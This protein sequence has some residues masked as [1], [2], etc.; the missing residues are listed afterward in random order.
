MSSGV[1]NSLLRGRKGR[2]PAVA[3]RPLGRLGSVCL[4]SSNSRAKSAFPADFQPVVTIKRPESPASWPSWLIHCNSLLQLGNIRII[5][6]AALWGE[7]TT[8]GKLLDGSTRSAVLHGAEGHSR[9]FVAPAGGQRGG[10][11]HRTRPRGGLNHAGPGS[12]GALLPCHFKIS[13]RA[14]VPVQSAI[15]GASALRLIHRNQIDVTK[16]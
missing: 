3:G 11:S 4:E 9:R 13:R 14:L 15:T 1:G 10:Q 7:G 12:V 5:S 2:Q 8:R 16:H 6:L